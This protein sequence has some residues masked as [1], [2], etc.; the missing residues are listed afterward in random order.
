MGIREPWKV[1]EGGSV[2]VAQPGQGFGKG[3]LVAIVQKKGGR[4]EMEAGR[5]EEG[6]RGLL[7]LLGCFYPIY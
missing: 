3:A 4:G 5:R 1:L 7:L 6:G 2:E